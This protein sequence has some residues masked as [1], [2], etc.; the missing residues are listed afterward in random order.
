MRVYFSHVLLGLVI[1]YLRFLVMGIY[2]DYSDIVYFL[3]VMLLRNVN[4]N[5][6][7]V[8]YNNHHF[9]GYLDNFNLLFINVIVIID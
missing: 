8:V 6:V 4:Y 7:Y 1:L 9:K 2:L 3:I 5:L